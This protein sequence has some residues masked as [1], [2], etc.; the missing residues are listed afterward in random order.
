MALLL[1]VTMVLPIGGAD[2]PVAALLNTF[3]GLAAAM[4]GLVLEETADRPLV[5]PAERH[6]RR[7]GPLRAATRKRLRV[8]AL[9]KGCHRQQFGGRDGALAAAAVD[10]YLEPRHPPPERVFVPW[11]RVDHS[12]GMMATGQWTWCITAWA[13]GPVCMPILAGRSLR[14][15]T[16]SPASCV[17]SNS[18]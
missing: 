11:Y 6:D 15:T 9:Q 8:A 2:T 16:S 10:A 5:D 12:C 7:P 1:G 13:I 14:P 18:C 17:A 3:T 4:A